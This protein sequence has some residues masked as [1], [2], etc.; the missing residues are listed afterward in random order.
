MNITNSSVQ[1]LSN[2]SL[3]QTLI[4]STTQVSQTFLSLQTP[5]TMNPLIDMVVIAIVVGLFTTLL[6]KYLTD[7]VAIKALRAEMK[8]KQK[9]MRE[10]LKT[11]PQKA[12][13]MQGEIMQKNMELMKHSFNFKVMAI[14]ILPMLFVFT[15]IR[16][17]YLHFGEILNLGFIS[18]EWL[19]T[20]IV[21]TIIASIVLKKLLKVA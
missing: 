15:Q 18:F 11:N 16:Q 14:T 17:G 20:Y 2:E 8:K 13:K 19:G 21:L 10:M 9:D 6:N 3:N 4:N 1:T 12:Q 7:Q 5:F